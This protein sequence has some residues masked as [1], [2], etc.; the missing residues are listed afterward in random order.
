MSSSYSTS[1]RVN[2]WKVL[3][4]N[5]SSSSR[6]R[7]CSNSSSRSSHRLLADNLWPILRSSEQPGMVAFSARLPASGPPAPSS[8]CQVGSDSPCASVVPWPFASLQT[9]RVQMDE[10]LLLPDTS[11]FVAQTTVYNVA[12]QVDAFS[13]RLTGMLLIWNLWRAAYPTERYCRMFAEGS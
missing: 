9:A 5:S 4:G 7:L 6:T 11:C 1:N 3:L 12:A 13:S 10:R 2:Y 8:S